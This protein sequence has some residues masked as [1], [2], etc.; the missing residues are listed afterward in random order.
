MRQNLLFVALANVF[1]WVFETAENSDPWKIQTV[2]KR[3]SLILIGQVVRQ[4]VNILQ[5]QH[6]SSTLHLVHN[7]Q[8]QPFLSLA[9]LIIR[10]IV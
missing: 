10:D 6:L 1:R 5:Y 7:N 9:D 3:I 8:S 4:I 2:L